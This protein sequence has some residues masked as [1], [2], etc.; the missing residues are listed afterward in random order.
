MTRPS[1]KDL[2]RVKV[3]A[4]PEGLWN[5]VVPYVYGP[6][7]LQLTVIAK[8]DK[9]KEVSKKWKPS[10]TEECGP[11]GSLENGNQQQQSLLVSAAVRGA[12]VGKIGGSTA[13]LPDT[14]PAAAAGPYAGRKVFVSGTYTVVGLA[15]TDCGRCSLR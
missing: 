5:M 7:L 1:W 15:S 3:T 14:S 6:R 13:D 4:Q 12:M 8:D 2:V 11:D 10:D 9:G